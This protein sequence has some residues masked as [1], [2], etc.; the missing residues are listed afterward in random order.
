LNFVIKIKIY[1][2]RKIF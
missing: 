1:V 2:G